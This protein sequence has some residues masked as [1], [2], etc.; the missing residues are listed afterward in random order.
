MAGWDIT[1]SPPKSSS[2][3]WAIAPDGIAEEVREADRVA[4]RIGLAQ[5][6]RYACVARLGRNGTDRQPGLGFLAAAYE[7]RCSRDGDPQLHTHEV[8]ANA[9]ETADGRRAA[10][11]GTMLYRWQQAADAVYQ[12]ALRAELTAHLGL[13]WT[14][15][16][17]LWEID[18]IPPRCAGCGPNAAR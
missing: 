6:E 17:E 18:G 1:F 7:H 13:T 3:L 15:R 9:V 16:A 4:R 14:L 5:F 8:I 2:A 12:A 10:L 11:D